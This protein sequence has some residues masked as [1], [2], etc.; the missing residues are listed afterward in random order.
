ML[1]LKTWKRS[2]DKGKVFDVLLTNL[3]KVFDCLNHE[4]LTPKLN[5]YGFSFLPLRLINDYSSKREDRTKIENTCSTLVDIIFGVPQSSI[6][7]QLLYNV[8]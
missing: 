3:S 6:L 1:M 5:G 7:G 8:F 4:L 2:I